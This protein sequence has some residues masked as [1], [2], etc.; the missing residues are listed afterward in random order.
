M[1]TLDGRRHDLLPPGSPGV[2]AGRV[3]VSLTF[4]DVGDHHRLHETVQGIGRRC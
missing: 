3:F 2:L 4:H 1:M